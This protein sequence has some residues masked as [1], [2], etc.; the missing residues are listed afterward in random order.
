MIKKEKCVDD[1]KVEIPKGNTAK[2]K[3]EKCNVDKVDNV[4]DKKVKI[5]K[6]NKSKV[7]NMKGDGYK[8]AKKKI[9]QTKS[10]KPVSDDSNTDFG[11][12]KSLLFNMY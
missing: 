1:K 9:K 8:I 10:M 2:V 11:L 6:G 7:K 3:K 12:M 4:D 5:P